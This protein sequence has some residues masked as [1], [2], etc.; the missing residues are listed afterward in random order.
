MERASTVTQKLNI[1]H[2]IVLQDVAETLVAQGAPQTAAKLGEILDF[3]NQQK[4]FM[5]ELQEAQKAFAGAFDTPLAR[6]RIDDE[7]A[8]DARQR[9][10]DI[11]EKLETIEI[12]G[13]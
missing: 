3:L 11:A 13:K 4:T 6:R 9:M 10:R 8:A 5:E 1:G 12:F 2:S 7:Y